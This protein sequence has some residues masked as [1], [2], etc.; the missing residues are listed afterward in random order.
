MIRGDWQI[1]VPPV[2]HPTVSR[3]RLPSDL[4]PR[5]FGPGLRCVGV[6]P[7][8]LAPAALVNGSVHRGRPWN[9]SRRYADVRGSSR[10]SLVV[11]SAAF[12]Y[13]STGSTDFRSHYFGQ[14]RLG[15]CRL[16]GVF[17]MAKPLRCVK[18]RAKNLCKSH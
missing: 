6:P 1:T 3:N 9:R 8:A 14:L 15:A 17:F 12:R 13:C 16:R 5:C 4:T 10:T 7:V 2:S 18:D 11:R